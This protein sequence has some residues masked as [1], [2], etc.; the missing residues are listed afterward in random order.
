MNR[1]EI[2][3]SKTKVLLGIAASILFVALGVFLLTKR[4]TEQPVLNPLL[5]L[6]TGILCILF[7]G[8]T[9][10]LGVRKLME[11]RIALIIDDTGIFENS[12][13]NSAGWIPWTE[14]TG[15][16]IGQVAS[17][18]FILI[19]VVNPEPYLN[20]VSGFKRKM[21]EANINLYNTPIAITSTT[22]NANFDELV[23]QLNERFEAVQR[24]G[25]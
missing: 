14:I 7:F 18:R 21:L 12:H 23:Q 24:N 4:A 25:I 10:I 13:S 6:I 20:K 16:R 11:R 17:T 2:T 22:L 3:L 9:A 15:I 8:T 1:I 19:D 5:M